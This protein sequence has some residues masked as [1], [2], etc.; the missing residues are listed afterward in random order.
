MSAI[1]KAWV[2]VVGG[3]HAVEHPEEVGG[4]GEGGIGLDDG[5]AFADAIEEGDDHGDLRGEAE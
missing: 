3:L 5:L 1:S 2:A 4:V